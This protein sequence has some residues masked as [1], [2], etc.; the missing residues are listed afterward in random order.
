[1]GSGSSWPG[2]EPTSGSCR[3]PTSTPS[4][5]IG[6]RSD[7]AAL[8]AL[9]GDLEDA[10]ADSDG[11]LGIDGDGGSQHP[12]DV[13]DLGDAEIAGRI[14]PDPEDDGGD[15]PPIPV[16]SATEILAL[17]SAIAYASADG[18]TVDYLV[19]SAVAGIWRRAYLD[20][21]AALAETENPCDDP[22]AERVRVAFRT[23]YD[24]ARAL[25]IPADYAF[26]SEGPGTELTLPNLMQLR[27]ASQV[28]SERRVG[29]WSGTGAGKTLSAVLASGKG[30][31][32]ARSHL[33]GDVIL[34]V[35]EYG[36]IPA[37]HTLIARGKGEA[38]H[39]MRHAWRDAMCDDFSELV[40][41]AT[42]RRVRGFLSQVS[43]EP[44][45]HIEM[46]ML[47]PVAVPAER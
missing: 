30:P 41:S 34:C 39:A 47:E 8:D 45:V 40:A 25:A 29:N 14:A 9:I 3:Q 2:C 36:L 42:G 11:A 37:E 1:M 24:E 6:G 7:A 19:A 31:V 27:V 26:R 38:V 12:G 4:A 15:V 35:L 22:Y 46:F 44:D 23:Q 18:E 21:A 20:E 17:A 32:H 33:I 43:L 28:L 13:A 5:L 16:V 10:L